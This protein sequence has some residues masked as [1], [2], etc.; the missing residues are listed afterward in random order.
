MLKP[1]QYSPHLL[2]PSGLPPYPWCQDYPLPK[3][4]CPWFQ[5]YRNYNFLGVRANLVLPQHP[6]CQG[7]N[8]AAAPTKL[9]QSPCS[10]CSHILKQIS[11]YLPFKVLYYTCC[12]FHLCLLYNHVVNTGS[13]WRKVV[14]FYF[15]HIVG[16]PPSRLI[17]QP[18]YATGPAV[19]LVIT[20]VML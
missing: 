12:S 17:G 20:S 15:I 9:I 2:F 13:S 3:L 7:N 5:D 19:A 14:S 16:F 8:T 1:F 11:H 4:Q 18:D 10:H 6:W